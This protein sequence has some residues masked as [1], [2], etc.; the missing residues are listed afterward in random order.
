M[1]V[2]S[3]Q[4]SESKN[5]VVTLT[6]P[7]RALSKP[8]SSKS[9]AH[10]FEDQ[11][12]TAAIDRM[13]GGGHGTVQKFVYARACPGHPAFYRDGRQVRGWRHRREQ[14]ATPSL[15]TAIPAMTGV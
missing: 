10:G 6:A 11:H 3:G 13:G 7:R 12:G 2:Y 5:G 4:H 8:E 14:E 15:R 1:P 9:F